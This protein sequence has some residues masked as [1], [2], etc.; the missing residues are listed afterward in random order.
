M[1]NVYLLLIIAFIMFL[2]YASYSYSSYYTR[3]FQR[4]ILVLDLDETLVHTSI[5][6]PGVHEFLREVTALFDEVVIFTAGT[7]PYASPVIDRLE[8]ESR[9]KLGRRFYR[10]SCSYTSAGNLVKDL[11]ILKERDLQYVRIV[12]NTP[13]AYALQQ[14]CGIPIKSFYG[15]MNDRELLDA[16]FPRLASWREQ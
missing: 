11:R 14:S 7:E 9:V 2:T 12:D 15:D 13:E 10:D 8:R 1:D 6:R 3:N 16:V 5:D 4:W